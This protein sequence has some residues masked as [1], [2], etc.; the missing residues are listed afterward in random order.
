MTKCIS[1]FIFLLFSFSTLQAQVVIINEDFEDQ[2]LTQNPEWFGDLINFSFFD[3]NGNTLLRLSAPGAGSSQLRTQS[4]T[5]YGSWEFMIDQDFPPSNSNRGFI[6]LMSD[7]EDLAG[8]VNGYALRTG[9]SSS[10]NYFRLFR[11]TNGSPTEILTGKLDISGGGAYQIKI[12]RDED[13]TWRLF[14]SKGFGSI[15]QIASNT[16][17]ITHTE[18]SYFGILLNY[19]VT[20]AEN[21]YF[22]NII[23]TST[24][25]FNATSAD[26]SR[27]TS[28]DLTFNYPINEAS[29]LPTKFQI[30][31]GVGFPFSV[32]LISDF[33]VQ[34]Q[35]INPLENGN[36]TVT[37]NDVESDFG[38]VIAPNSLLDFSV[39][40]PFKSTGTEAISNSK[41]DLFFT[42]EVE[43]VFIDP[44]N[45]EIAGK[46]NPDQVTQPEAGTIRLGFTTPLAS[47]KY[48]LSISKLQS[49]N[50]WSL[51]GGNSFNLFIFDEFNSGNLIISEFFYRTPIHW[52]TTEFNRPGY[53]ELF[54]PSNRF[55]NLRDFT[56]NGEII[57][58]TDLSIS[59][60]E[61]LVVTRGKPVFLERFG[62]RNFFEAENFPT[63]SLT[64]ENQIIIRSANAV[65]VDSLY[66]RSNL[67]GGNG[68][69][70]ER[71]SYSASSIFSDNW[72]ESE[73]AL[74]GSPGLSN[75]VTVPTNPP[76]VTDVSFP[77]PR[78]L[79]VKFSRALSPESVRELSNFRLANSAVFESTGYN[80]EDRR[81]LIFN[82]VENL[83]DQFDYTFTYENVYDIFGNSISGIQ[84]FD[85]RFLNPFRVLAGDSEGGNTVLV[86]FTQP[87]NVST[88]SISNFQLS[89]GT[90]PTSI[91]FPNSENIRLNFPE[92][93]G[94][95]S[96]T[97]F[98][99][100]IQSIVGWSIE[101]G[102]T[103][104]F[105][106]FDEYEPGD[107]VINEFMYNTPAGYSK[108]V[109]LLNTSDKILN[110]RDW[111]LRRAERATNNGGIIS[112]NPLAI[113]PNG[114]VVIAE[115]T[116]KMTASFGPGHWFQMNNFPGITQTRDDEIR[117]FDRN[118]NI[119]DSLRYERS[120]WGGTD[121][122][123]E[124]RTVNVATHF[125]EN[126]GESPNKRLGTPGLAN[127]VEQ[128]V[129]PPVW[130]NLR[131]SGSEA[132]V[133]RFNERL[134]KK[135][136]I[137]MGNYSIEPTLDIF[138]INVNRNIVEIIFNG[139]LQSNTEYEVTIKE[140]TD[141]FGNTLKSETRSVEYLHFV[142]AEPRQVVINEIL[143]RRLKAGSPEFVEIYNRSEKNIDLSGWTLSNASGSTTLPAGTYIKGYDYLVFTDV[144][145]FAAKSGKIHYLSGFQSL[146]NNGDA[147]VLKNRVDTVIDSLFYLPSWGENT[148]GVS[149]ERRDPAAISIDPTNWMPSSADGGSTPAA[150]N[151][152]FE[153][154]ETP[155]EIIF[156]NLFHPDSLEV[157]FSKFIDLNPSVSQNRVGKT[158][159][160]FHRSDPIAKSQL[161]VSSEVPETN[162]L[163]NNKRAEVLFYDP[164]R[165]NRIILDTDH[166]IPGEEV[167]ISIE[168]FGDFQGNI[169][170]SQE[171]PVAQPVQAGDLVFNEIMY[172]P[173][174]DNRENLTHQSEYIEIVNR[175]PYAISVEG[176][177][178]HDRPDNNNQVTTI[179]PVN[180]TSK[181][182]PANG[183][184]LFHAE[185]QTN[186]FTDSKT[187]VF[188]DLEDHLEKQA[189]RINRTTLSLPMAG[190]EVYLADST[191]TIIDMVDYRPEWHNPNLIDTRG[192]S[193]ERVTPNGDTNDPAN[194]S[195]NT[196]PIG[197]TPATQ[198]SI[199]QQSPEP[200]T[201]TGI[202]LTPNP[203]SPDGDGFDDN[204]FINYKFDDPDY[205]LRIRI[206]DRYGRLVRTLV[207]AHQAGFEGSIIWNGLTDA[208]QSNRIGIYIIYVE[209]YNSTTGKNRNFRKTTVLAR[210]F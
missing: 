37:I 36:Y 137:Q 172:D 84:E 163:I 161:S 75:T 200:L 3:N 207:D 95:G 117:L 27:A 78:E 86:Q 52:R 155:P 187:A 127:E 132:F 180:S 148:P 90:N 41:I 74:L 120:E 173:I 96:Y 12:E 91:E 35:F 118:G 183:V 19:T 179:N 4:T 113:E 44:V 195:T 17:D 191:R 13:G 189:L 157:R 115:D 101:S 178:L 93:F 107:I 156:A 134:D 184:L 133:L 81:I 152:R 32:S 24:E 28:I 190:R 174:R 25:K 208:G 123:L 16:V 136:A 186:I 196:Q 108:Y 73:D 87:L 54:N 182:I 192:K 116:T 145:S 103:F 69:S 50:G 62:E 40:N 68:R 197:G 43:G 175:R 39:Q 20:R 64:T 70:L 141:L 15:P 201:E 209:A 185:D 98:I 128:D 203:F 77:A 124:R 94:I 162:F 51:V 206:Y 66:Y 119:A 104:N 97:L 198:N 1:F 121:V 59:P 8:N 170:P 83:L 65:T 153:L 147:V 57:S 109:E 80:T 26:V 177:L 58:S 56:F 34:L 138:S 114:Y 110:L 99:N 6:F 193:L 164:G 106:V 135:T 11:F 61:Y 42:E 140:I 150:E 7:R 38:E 105:F 129:S 47:G 169:T 112:S 48:S 79:R 10:P 67:W 139:N 167:I 171:Q 142:E 102:T 5:A 204:L 2:N 149:L 131:T 146:S 30:N 202:S 31:E 199:F 46:G 130:E 14:E 154:D 60:N 143:Y 144:E 111:E 181:W 89:D 55:L 71:K 92:A 63:L 18:S 49:V 23:V 194:W 158:P 85:F 21:F 160:Q 166:V 205:L 72:G 9:E 126:W 29:L 22:D 33:L 88:V 176:I 188:F 151:S 100:N 45:F 168:N 76:E 165:G 159:G 210:Q 122:A 53:I 125:V 82:L